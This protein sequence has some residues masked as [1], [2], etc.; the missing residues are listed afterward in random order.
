MK[1]ILKTPSRIHFGILDMKGD[2]KRMYGSVGVALSDP[3]TIIEVSDANDFQVFGEERAPLY[4]KRVRNYF[5]IKRG[6]NIRVVESIPP[7]VGLGSGT[8]L[9]L[10]I[11]YAMLKH[12]GM[13]VS[14]ERLAKYWEGGRDQELAYI[15]SSMEALSSMEGSKMMNYRSSYLGM[16]F[17]RIGSS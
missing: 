1:T 2:L 8:Q 14:I 16:N 6:M 13:E 17:P 5:K 3:R 10:G 4:A 9:S 7:H 12:V 15:P 11:G